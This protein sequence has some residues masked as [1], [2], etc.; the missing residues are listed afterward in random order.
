MNGQGCYKHF[1]NYFY[2]GSFTNGLPTKLATKLVISIKGSSE[3]EGEKFKISEPT[4]LFD[5]VVRSM[6]DDN[7][8]FIGWFINIIKFLFFDII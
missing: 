5:V 8:V 4:Q 3:S 6:N 2:E 7:E 1:S